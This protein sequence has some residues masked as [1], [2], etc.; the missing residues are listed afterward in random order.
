MEHFQQELTS[1]AAVLLEVTTEDYIKVSSLWSGLIWQENIK[2]KI[3][4]A[5]LCARHTFTLHVA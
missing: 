1:Y 2:H 4:V 3:A 5:V